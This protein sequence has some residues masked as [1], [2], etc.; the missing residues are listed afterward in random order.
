[1]KRKDLK[2]FSPL[3]VLAIF[4]LA[5]WSLHRTLEEYRFSDILQQIRE[6]PPARI[7]GA[8]GM[9][10]VCYLALT[11]HD[12]LGLRY[13]GRSLSLG[14]ITVA[15]FTSYAFSRNVGFALL[16]GGSVRY[17]FYSSWGLK[18]EEIV[19][20]IAFAAMS[21]I[22]GMATMGGSIL[23]FFTAALP[24]LPQ[25]PL[26]LLK[27]VGALALVAVGSYLLLIFFRRNPML[28]WG[29]RLPVP[30]FRQALAQVL[31]G[32]LDWMLTASV[33][34]LLIPPTVDLSLPHFLQI[35]LLAQLAVIITHVPGGLGVF[36]SVFLLLTPGLSAPALFG[37]LLVYRGIYFLLPFCLA[38]VT[39]LCFEALQRRGK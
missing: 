30:T 15:S 4:L 16:S 37:A 13:L 6:F 26:H 19:R 3:L 9:T 1:M 22:L 7:L 27:P 12:H 31:V 20:L 11:L 25:L 18:A 8:A 5:V 38:A 21:F 29:W 10:A 2:R 14:R 28:L 36:E 39:L 32:S 34:F 23:L 35:Y 33:L 17:R 24:D